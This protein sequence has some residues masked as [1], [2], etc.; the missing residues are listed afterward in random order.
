MPAA[1]SMRTFAGAGILTLPGVVGQLRMPNSPWSPLV[2]LLAFLPSLGTLAAVWFLLQFLRHHIVPILFPPPA[3]APAAPPDGGKLLYAAFA[4]LVAA[5]ALDA[6]M[7]LGS[8]LYR[9][10][11]A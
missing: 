1:L 2:M 11:A 6:L 4:S 5:I 10:V 9:A 8:I 7:A 3:E